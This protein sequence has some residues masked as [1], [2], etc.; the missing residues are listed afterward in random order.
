MAKPVVNTGAA[1][2]SGKLL[3]AERELERG[4]NANAKDR[5]E[6]ALEGLRRLPGVQQRNQ[7]LWKQLSD[8]I[9]AFG[10]SRDP[11]PLVREIIRTFRGD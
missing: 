3:E 6:E 7:N 10:S 5:L 8:A 9:N 11:L 4:A 2:I 1:F